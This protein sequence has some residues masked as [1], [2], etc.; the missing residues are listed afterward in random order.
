MGTHIPL[1]YKYG[2]KRIINPTPPQPTEELY[3][4]KDDINPNQVIYD[5]ENDKIIIPNSEDEIM[6][7]PTIK[8]DNVNNS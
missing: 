6:V 8:N 7:T 4:E 1:F 5:L 3:W 2:P